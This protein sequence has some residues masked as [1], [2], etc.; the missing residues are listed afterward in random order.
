MS[1]APLQMIKNSTPPGVRGPFMSKQPLGLTPRSDVCVGLGERDAQ[2][3]ACGADDGRGYLKGG[4]LHVDCF[5][6]WTI[7]AKSSAL[8]GERAEP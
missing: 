7:R 1:V 5:L 8:F 3:G 6:A 2:E 4:L